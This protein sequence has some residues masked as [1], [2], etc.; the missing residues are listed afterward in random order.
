MCEYLEEEIEELRATLRNAE[1]DLFVDLRKNVADTKAELSVVRSNLADTTTTLDKYR[2]MHVKM[3]RTNSDLRKS[4]SDLEVTIRTLTEE[5]D[6]SREWFQGMVSA[7]ADLSD[8]YAKSCDDYEKLAVHFIWRND[9][10][11]SWQV[12]ISR[13]RMIRVA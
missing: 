7:Y 11:G 8:R 1:A 2:G 3:S 9:A 13:I 6:L 10:D 5:R 12:L 4:V